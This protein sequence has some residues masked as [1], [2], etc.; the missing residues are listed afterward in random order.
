MRARILIAL[1]L[2]GALAGCQESGFDESKETQRP[3]KVQD[4][5]NPLNGTKVPGQAERPATLTA[6]TLGDT[7]AMGVTPV[8]ASDVPEYMRAEASGVRV[9]KDSDISGIRAATPDV[10]LGTK[11]DQGSEYDDLS[12]IA[13]TILTDEDD[14]KL[15]LREHGEALGRTNDAEKLLIDWDN[16]LA[17]VKRVLPE[18]AA[19]V[20]LIGQND[21][22]VTPGPVGKTVLEDLGLKSGI[23]ARSQTLRIAAGPEWSS[24]GLLAARAALEDV[25][26]AL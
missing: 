9:V 26:K 12:K 8:V 6:D 17:R 21:A 2:V 10:I 5:M 1:A 3:L 14:W 15:N 4:A 22:P 23:G 13:P 19:Y 25:A 20:L 18:D 11:Q 16:R 7:I 24:G